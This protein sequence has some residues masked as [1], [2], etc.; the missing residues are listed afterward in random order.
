MIG[1]IYQFDSDYQW[2]YD[3]NKKLQMFNLSFFCKTFFLISLF[4]VV[5]LSAQENS[6]NEYKYDLDNSTVNFAIMSKNPGQQVAMHFNLGDKEQIIKK[7]KIFVS[8]GTVE[9]SK[10]NI[11]I[12]QLKPD[13]YWADTV[14]INEVVVPFSPKSTKEWSEIDLE[15]K[16][17]TVSGNVLISLEWVTPTG[18]QEPYTSFFIGADLNVENHNGYIKH[19]NGSWYPARRFGSSGAKNFYIRLYTKNK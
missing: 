10:A 19:P 9:N 1:R 8:S 3:V 11:H 4:S 16:G 12:L 5:T 7:I 18:E 14:A 2:Y 6:I 15:D 13:W 17:I